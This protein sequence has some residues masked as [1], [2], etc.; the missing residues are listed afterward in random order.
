MSKTKCLAMILAGGQGS[1]LGALTKNIA[2]PAVPFGGKYRIIDFP[3]S[4]CAN[5]G[6]DTVGV[7]TQY[8]PLELHTYLGTGNAWDLD[9][10]NGG[11]FILPPYARDK[12]ADWYKGTADAIYQ[13]LNFIDMMDPDYVLILSGDHIYTMDYSKMLDVHRANKADATIGVFEVPW[14][15]APRFG[16]MNTDSVDG[17][18]IEFEEKPPQPK[19]NLASM[20]IYIFN[21]EFLSRYLK[22]DAVKEDSEHDFGKNIIPA[23]LG[24]NARLYSYAFEGY[25]K[26]VGTIESLWQANMD[27]LAD[28]PPF[29]FN[30]AWTIYSSNPSLPPHY[31][32]PE[33]RVH[34]SMLNEGSQILGEVD[35]SVL[36]SGVKIGKG[37]KVTNSVIMPFTKVEENAVIDH[38]IVAQ[39]CIITAGAAV[40]GEDGAI[41]V[42]PEG[43]VVEARD[44]G[45][46]VS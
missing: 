25:W 28:E 45:Q 46:Q 7:L 16:I 2:K 18:I 35:H 34:N 37:A 12:G 13:N 26:D 17:R 41:A 29:S 44:E 23:M 14:D 30:S 10:S 11:V 40:T 24:D 4:N 19:S 6:I 8:R 27:L 3:L 20:G 33:A 5:S 38:A 42:V 1:R 43:E 39:N 15:E 36:F 21:R 32:G 9:K 31:V 22:A